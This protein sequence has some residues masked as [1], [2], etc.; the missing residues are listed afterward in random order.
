MQE[1]ASAGWMQI[2]HFLHHRTWAT[3][4]LGFWGCLSQFLQIRKDDPMCLKPLLWLYI[5]VCPC[6]CRHASVY[7]CWHDCVPEC[8]CNCMCM[9]VVCVPYGQGHVWWRL[10]PTQPWPQEE[11]SLYPQTV[12]L[13]LCFPWITL[14][15]MLTAPSLHSDMSEPCL[16][17]PTHHFHSTQGDHCT[18]P[19]FHR[20]TAPSTLKTSTHR[21][22]RV[23]ALW[24]SSDLEKV[25]L[26]PEAEGPH[27]FWAHRVHEAPL[28]QASGKTGETKGQGHGRGLETKRREK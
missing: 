18:H 4:A 9:C 13:W 26:S 28:I 24:P 25:L 8:L 2:H 10:S 11:S 20:Q 7:L 3:M 5:C 23:T 12:Q 22:R 27:S 6:K 19:S 15:F 16:L 1:K 21:Q 17:F 14:W